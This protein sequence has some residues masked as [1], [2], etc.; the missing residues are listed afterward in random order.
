MT[1]SEPFWCEDVGVYLQVISNEEADRICRDVQI[2]FSYKNDHVWEKDL[3]P[4]EYLREVDTP[5]SFPDYINAIEVH[6]GKPE[7]EPS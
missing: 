2:Y 4:Q 5:S 7:Y 6:V 1:K 3:P